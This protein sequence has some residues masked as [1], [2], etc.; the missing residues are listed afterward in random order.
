MSPFNAGWRLITLASFRE[1]RERARR[2]ANYDAIKAAIVEEHLRG[3]G[4]IVLEKKYDLK[5]QSAFRAPM[6]YA[7]KN[8]KGQLCLFWRR[9]LMTEEVGPPR[10][11]RSDAE[12]A[13]SVY[14]K[15]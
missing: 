12:R 7:A 14:C 6:Y 15:K 5:D 11:D 1:R 10:D 2:R 13:K 9:D 3:F 4:G 8:D